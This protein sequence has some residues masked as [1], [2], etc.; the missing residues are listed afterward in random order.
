MTTSQIDLGHAVNAVAQSL[1]TTVLRT[2]TVDDLMVQFAAVA[3]IRAAEPHLAYRYDGPDAA[4]RRRLGLTVGDWT[5]TES[6]ANAVADLLRHQIAGT[7][8]T[9]AQIRNAAVSALHAALNA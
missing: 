3:V 5:I 7:D 2:S 6:A 8:I 1:H 4:T 9:D